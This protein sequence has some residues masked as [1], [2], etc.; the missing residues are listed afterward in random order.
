MAVDFLGSLAE[1]VQA[2]SN[3]YE[4]VVEVFE[5]RGEIDAEIFEVRTLCDITERQKLEHVDLETATADVVSAR[6][7][8]RSQLLLSKSAVQAHADRQT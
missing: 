4:A 7:A 3:E 1:S 5:D 6:Y 8:T 2:L